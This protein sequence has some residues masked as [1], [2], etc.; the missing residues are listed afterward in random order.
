[1]SPEEHCPSVGAS[2]NC[3]N[4]IDVEIAAEQWTNTVLEALKAFIP[5]K[6][7]TV[8]TNDKPWYNGSL[9]RLKRKVDRIHKRA[10]I[11]NYNQAWVNYRKIRNE[12]IQKC[13]ESESKYEKDQLFKL[14][15]C[16]FTT[17]ECWSLYKSVLGKTANHDSPPF[18]NNGQLITGN[19]D[20]AELFNKIFLENSTVDDTGR[21]LPNLRDVDA[22]AGSV[23][24][25]IVI[26]PTDVA[27]QFSNLN[28]SKA[29]GP[30]GLGPKML[31]QLEP[32]IC[33]PMLQ[34]FKASI[35]QNIVPRI[36]KYANVIPIHKKGDKSD[37]TN[38]R[39]VSLL[40]TTGK[41]LEKIVFKYL[42]NHFRVNFSISPWQSDFMPGCSTICQLFEIYHK[43]CQGVENGKEVRV[44]FLDISRAFDRV[45][46]A[47][48]L[49]KL[50]KNGIKG[51]VLAWIKNNL[52]DR[53]Q[54]V[55]LNGQ[56]SDWRTILTGIPQGSIL[57]PLLFLIFIND[58]T[59]VVRFTQIRL[60]ADDTCL[61]LTV[62]NRQ[63]AQEFIDA[64]LQAIYTWSNKWLVKFSV[65][66]TKS[67]LISNKH[68]KHL[69]PPL[70]MNNAVLEEIN[71]HKHLGITLSH[72]LSW[73]THIE[74]IAGKA[75]R[76]LD[77]IKSFKFKMSRNHLEKFY[78]SFV[79]PI[80]EYGDALWDG[81]QD[82]EL[83]KL[84]QV[85]VRAMRI[86]I[87][88]A[89]ERQVLKDYM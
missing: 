64:D 54:R 49:H 55:C 52:K 61:F 19:N 77:I 78:L 23:F 26:T 36:W 73:N 22:T 45:W 27:D 12:Y 20:K 11:S 42:F 28:I 72:N 5:N 75:M 69:N 89:T 65:P 70:T 34:L 32:A 63:Q 80:L 16:S 46:H 33:V 84:D 3:N 6:L 7:V 39:P 31:K 57:G 38:Y 85:H 68:D 82:Y 53:Q 18:I 48:L 58:I 86:I 8:R 79:L 87:T 37:P 30:D 47:G 56:Y 1:M 83:D 17:K 24:D 13:R 15:N 14:S 35:E 21:Q 25:K 74:E 4:Y 62:D 51:N 66:K 81:A 44:V 10:K 40:A 29:Y 60:F 59:E 88:G 76:R 71:T 9:I 43:F 67:L 41:M 2:H 50:E